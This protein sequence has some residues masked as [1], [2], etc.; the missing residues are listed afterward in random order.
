MQTNLRW[1]MSVQLVRLQPQLTH[2]GTIYVAQRCALC[3]RQGCVPGTTPRRGEQAAGAPLAANSATMAT[4]AALAADN[5][6]LAQQLTQLAQLVQDMAGRLRE[7]QAQLEG[8]TAAV[9]AEHAV[10]QAL[11]RC[12]QDK[13]LHSSVLKL[14]SSL[15]NRRAGVRAVEGLKTWIA[16]RTAYGVLLPLAPGELREDAHS[17][18]SL[19]HAVAGGAAPGAVKVELLRLL[20]Q[21]AGMDVDTVDLCGRTA[22]HRAAAVH[23]T[24]AVQEL[25][26]LG[27]T[28]KAV[29]AVGA[30]AAEYARRAGSARDVGDK[31]ARK[32]ATLLALA[33]PETG[34]LRAGATAPAQ[35]EQ[36]PSLPFGSPL[37]G[38][39]KRRPRL[40]PAGAASPALAAKLRGGS[41]Q[42]TTPS[43]RTACAVVVLAVDNDMAWTRPVE[44]RAQPRVYSRVLPLLLPGGASGGKAQY[45]TVK[46]TAP[47]G[48]AVAAAIGPLPGGD[49]S[50]VRALAKACVKQ[51]KRTMLQDVAEG[52]C[53]ADCAEGGV[54]PQVQGT[55]YC[56][57]S[58]VAAG[59]A[60]VVAGV[61]APGGDALE[62]LFVP[63]LAPLTWSAVGKG[64]G[65]ERKR[66]AVI[67]KVKGGGGAAA[68]EGRGLEGQVEVETWQ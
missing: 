21:E 5:A 54:C 67:G 16:S 22:L 32:V 43:D 30:T 25:L 65:E 62:Q 14:F 58:A 6:A 42:P 10:R 59:K 29:D 48:M 33:L 31:A 64:A 9:E 57:W 52:K 46:A 38:Y 23:G 47:R 56:E 3:S 17:G 61:D 68:G 2:V 13:Q 44:G 66:G 19:L 41:P 18:Q 26:R 49:E 20:V 7:T 36:L 1:R 12:A 53:A 35:E 37:R 34:T 27:A 11:L 24:E 55:G 4:G 28:A 50:A 8:V 39:A 45:E 60:L 63:L 15:Q 40:H 51:W